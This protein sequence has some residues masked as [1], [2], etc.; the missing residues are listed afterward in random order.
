MKKSTR[1]SVIFI[2]LLVIVAAAVYYY[3]PVMDPPNVEADITEVSEE[4]P[5]E[6]VK[7]IA[8]TKEFNQPA[9]V[10]DHQI[11]YKPHYTLSYNKEHEQPDWV[12]YTLYPF[13]DSISVKRKNSFRPDPEVI[14]G[15]ATL[16]D[17][18]RSGYD[19]GHLA[20]SK[21]FSFSKEAMKDTY[22]MSNMSPQLPGFNRDIWRKLE[23]RIY[24]LSKESDSLY[25][26]T[27]PVLD[28]ILGS[29]GDN[30][31]SIPRAYYKTV[32]KFKD[33]KING[34][35]FLLNNEKNSGSFWDFSTSIDSIEQVTGIDFYYQFEKSLQD[36]IESNT[37]MEGFQ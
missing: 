29:I 33:G 18:K 22:F 16:A 24:S 8:F 36:R 19:R 14:G 11:L 12:A 35:G 15:S 28:N 30:K 6:E 37:S 25:V 26:V 20:P 3:N 21:A 31:V 5:A 13:P 1:N 32:V 4:K 17:Y 23:A 2:I 7:V 9:E 34:L 27:G 10:P